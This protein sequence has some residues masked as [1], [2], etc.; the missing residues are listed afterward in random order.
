MALETNLMMQTGLLVSKTHLHKSCMYL[1]WLQSKK[2]EVTTI[3]N[4]HRY[5]AN[6]KTVWIAMNT[7]VDMRWIS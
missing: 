4:C 7:F 5:Q 2:I 1:I 3:V 6:M